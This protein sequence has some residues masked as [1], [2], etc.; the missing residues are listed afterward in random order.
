MQVGRRPDADAVDQHQR[1]GARGRPSPGPVRCSCSAPN[2]HSL[3]DVSIPVHQAGEGRM[4]RWR[5][6]GGTR[7]ETARRV[8]L[9][10]LRLREDGSEGG[11]HEQPLQRAQLMEERKI[12]EGQ[13][14][15]FNET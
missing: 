3:V 13:V 11:V 6:E 14:A 9:I 2:A 4:L 1:I 8:E 10:D 12:G 15:T 5:I 7:S